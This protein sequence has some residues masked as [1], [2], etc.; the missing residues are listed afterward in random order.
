MTRAPRIC[1]VCVMDDGVAPLQFDADGQCSSCRDAQRR[2]PHEYFPNAEGQRRLEAMVRT[3]KEQGR[4]RPY[5]CMVG[6]SGG[7]DSAYLVHIMRTRFDLRILAVHV[8]GGWNSEAAIHNIENLVRALDVDLYTYVVEWQEMRDLQL[9]FLRAGVLNQDIPQDHAFFATLY[10]VA[11]ER[12]IKTFLSGVNFATE[13]VSQPNSGYPS[14]DG[15]HIRSIHAKFGHGRLA[16]YPILTIPQYLWLTRVRGLPVIQKPLNWVEYNKDE[17]KSE[18]KT[19]YGWNEYGTKHSESRFTKFYQEIY[20][21]RKLSFDKRRLHLSS[22]IVTK[23]ITREAALDELA[24]PIIDAQRSR[25]E[26]KFIAKKLGISSEELLVLVDAPLTYHSRFAGDQWLLN[27]LSRSR[28][29][30]Q[31]M[32]AAVRGKANVTSEKAN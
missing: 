19:H 16:T 30:A 18:L 6:L 32:T 24:T 17:A 9:S 11:R 25:I 26:T 23:C 7:I 2:W 12:G 20:L 1:T 14:I 21:P 28:N 5:D 10:R 22:L 29:I 27:A 15:R 3:L 4:G 8:D 31:N 13:G